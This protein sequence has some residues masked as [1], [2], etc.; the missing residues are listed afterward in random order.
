MWHYFWMMAFRF[1]SLAGF[2]A[3]CL[4]TSDSWKISLFGFAV[5]TAISSIYSYLDLINARL[6]GPGGDWDADRRNECSS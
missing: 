1:V 3:S 4:V 2:I 6:G 5:M